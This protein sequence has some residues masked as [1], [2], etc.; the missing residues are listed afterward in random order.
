MEHFYNEENYCYASF[1]RRLIAYAIDLIIIFIT[2]NLFYFLINGVI[3]GFEIESILY[4]S[5]WYYLLEIAIFLAYSI[6]LDF[7]INGTLGK[8]FLGIVL[9]N[10]NYKYISLKQSIIRNIIKYIP[11]VINTF[12]LKAITSKNIDSYFGLKLFTISIFLFIIIG[13]LILI[14]KKKQGLHDIVAKTIIIQK[15]YDNVVVG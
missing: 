1:F 14:T 3:T 11:H 12:I 6:F 9:L 4:K 13:S 10:H 7:K 2:L 8:K 5:N 15:K